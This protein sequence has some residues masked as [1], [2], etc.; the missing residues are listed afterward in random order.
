[1]QGISAAV[2]CKHGAVIQWGQ[3]GEIFLVIYPASE[4]ETAYSPARHNSCN[5][6]YGIIIQMELSRF[7]MENNTHKTPAIRINDPN[8]NRSTEACS[9]TCFEI[10]ISDFIIF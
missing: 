3:A 6:A 2:H 5:V 9:F 1:M 7:F 4:I 10:Y 8:E